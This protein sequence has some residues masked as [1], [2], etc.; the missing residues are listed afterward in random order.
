MATNLSRAATVSATS[1]YHRRRGSFTADWTDTSSFAKHSFDKRVSRDDLALI[2]KSSKKG[3]NV[4]AF[5]IPI[6]G[7]LPSP[8]HSPRTSSITRTT[9]VRTSTPD[10]VEDGPQTGVIAV[11][12][13]IGSPTQLGDFAPVQW[14]PRN[15]AM[16][17]VMAS[18]EPIPEAIPEPVEDTQQKSRKWGLFRSKSK[19]STRPAQP[20]RALTDTGNVSTTSLSSSGMPSSTPADH[21]SRRTPKYKPIVIRSHTEPLTAEPAEHVDE[22]PLTAPTLVETPLSPGKLTREKPSL[23]RKASKEAKLKESAP[24]GLGRKMTLRGLRGDSSKKRSE[25]AFVPPPSSPPP[26]PAIPR[27]LLDVEIPSIKMDRYSVM[28]NSVLQPPQGSA[29]SLL[30]RRQATLDHL[31]TVKDAI[32]ENRNDTR[33][34]RRA[35]SP[36]PSPSFA[37]QPDTSKPLPSPR[38][39]ANTT[40]ASID[41]PTAPFYQ[42]DS[43]TVVAPTPRVVEVSRAVSQHNKF[44]SQAAHYQP[45]L[46]SK[47][48]RRPSAP[49]TEKVSVAVV[50]QVSSPVPAPVPAPVAVP[51]ARSKSTSPFT[52]SHK[53]PD[54]PQHTDD[55]G[56]DRAAKGQFSSPSDPSGQTISPPA[57]ITSSLASP[58]AQATESDP[59]EAL[60]NAVEVSIARQISVSRQQR[61]ML[62]PLKSNPSVRHRKNGSPHGPGY[63]HIEKDERLSETNSSTP[64]LVHPRELSHSPDAYQVHRKSEMVILEES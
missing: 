27:S 8:E 9:W 15:I 21:S 22:A 12:M 38:F 11:G 55:E 54:S 1:G 10:S 3:N 39:R 34:P 20:Q 49:S 60:R 43:P 35:T 37:P 56:D 24:G 40:P 63:I 30:A 48:N 36:Q 41:S 28:F 64:T 13:A 26:I 46:V 62:H 61:K 23:Q 18:P 59:Q 16:N 42:M 17:A 53:A 58:K 4:T 5:H 44:A 7:R 33:R 29:S 57:S 2:L 51:T 31:K 50:G 32:A 52:P 25:K 47:F 6:H 14:S 19:R 45:A